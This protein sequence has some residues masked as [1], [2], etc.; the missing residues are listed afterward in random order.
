MEYLVN[1]GILYL[2]L[3]SQVISESEMTK[4]R[5]PCSRPD[6][7][8]WRWILTLDDHASSTSL[9]LSHSLSKIMAV[10]PE[11]ASL[12]VPNIPSWSWGLLFLGSVFEDE[13]QR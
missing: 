7:N 11:T 13:L 2:T 6:D 3:I 12:W 8:Q 5:V 1:S 10:A 4:L 9:L